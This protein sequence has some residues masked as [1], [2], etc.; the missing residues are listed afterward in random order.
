M[1]LEETK[2]C[3][4]A[5]DTIK[6]AEWFSNKFMKLYEEKC[7]LAIFGAKR[8]TEIIVKIGEGAIK[9]GNEQNLVGITLDQSL[10]FKTHACQEP[11]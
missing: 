1:F 2:A 8:D 4:Y 3:N 11:L 7:H 10:S 9:E 5:D 6:T